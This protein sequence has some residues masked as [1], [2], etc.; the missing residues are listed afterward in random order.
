MPTTADKSMLG[1]CR[2]QGFC[3]LGDYDGVGF[4]ISLTDKG[5]YAAQGE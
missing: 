5:G 2:A 1:G 3:E 4:G